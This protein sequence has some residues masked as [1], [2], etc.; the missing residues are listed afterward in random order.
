MRTEAIWERRETATKMRPIID[1]NKLVSHRLRGYGPTENGRSALVRACAS[2]VPW[3]EVDTRVAR[4]GSIFVHHNPRARTHP[5]DRPY[6]AAVDGAA[7]RKLRYHTGE[8]L[9]ELDECLRLFRERSHATQRLCIDM[10]DF[11]HESTHVEIVDRHGLNDRVAWLSW[12]PLSLAR[13]REAGAR[14]PL[15]LAHCNLARLRAAGLL[16]EAAFAG[17]SLRLSRLVL[18]GV[19]QEAPPVSLGLG[20]QHGMICTRLPGPVERLLADSGGGVCVHRSLVSRPLMRYCR[21]TGLQLWVFKV[22]TP[23]AYARYAAHDEISIVFCD[24]APAV[25]ECLPPV[26]GDDPGHRL[27]RR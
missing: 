7:V 2:P 23:A 6:F 9:L 8:A 14:G 18:R 19:R 11:G 17:A 27:A 12:I 4:D 10:K 1:A 15:V 13:L 20:F 16:V 21:T 24:D 26:A 22:A 5:S 3:L 25:L